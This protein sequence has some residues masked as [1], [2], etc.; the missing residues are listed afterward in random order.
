[1]KKTY[2]LDL[3]IYEPANMYEVPIVVPMKLLTEDSTLKLG[4]HSVVLVLSEEEFEGIC[5]WA[6]T[7]AS[8]L[9]IIGSEKLD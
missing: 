4:Y 8:I 7:H 2:Q 9:K 6:R 1:M 5:E 3:R